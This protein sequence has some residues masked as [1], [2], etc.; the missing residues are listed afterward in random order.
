M[1]ELA[2]EPKR[3]LWVDRAGHND[4]LLFAQNQY[5]TALKNFSS[6]VERSQHAQK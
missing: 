3:H 4:V 5:I 6:I 2:R 1:Y